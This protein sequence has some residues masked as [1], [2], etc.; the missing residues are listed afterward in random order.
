MA[1]PDTSHQTRVTIV[2]LDVGTLR[3]S[4]VSTVSLVLFMFRLQRLFMAGMEQ[5]LSCLSEGSL[6]SC[7]AQALVTLVKARLRFSRFP[8]EPELS[9][10]ARASS[11]HG[12]SLF[13]A[14]ESR[15]F[16]VL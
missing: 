1:S 12:P 4:Y 16:L 3:S 5:R 9:R 7:S 2:C 6:M 14:R 15:N 8:K 13:S 11:M 10:R